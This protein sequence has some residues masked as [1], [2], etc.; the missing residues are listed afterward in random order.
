MEKLDSSAQKKKVQQKLDQTVAD[1]VAF[2]HPETLADEH[3]ELDP[4][5]VADGEGAPG[6]EGGAGLLE[7]A[8]RPGRLTRALADPADEAEQRAAQAGGPGGRGGPPAEEAAARAAG[9]DGESEAHADELRPGHEE[10]AP[11]GAGAPEPG[12]QPLAQAALAQLQQPRRK[13]PVQGRVREGVPPAEGLPPGAGLRPWAPGA[14]LQEDAGAP[15]A[16]A[17]GRGR[18]EGRL[19]GALLL[20]ERGLLAP[21]LADAAGHG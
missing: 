15:A 11:E 19:R 9:V 14:G 21:Q 8:G 17:E 7:G 6:P 18:G 16:A 12:L 1:R 5:V 13:T 10:V 4:A 2:R 3:F 20:Q